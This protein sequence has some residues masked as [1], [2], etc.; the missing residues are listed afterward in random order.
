MYCQIPIFSFSLQKKGFLW[1]FFIFSGC[2]VMPPRTTEAGRGF[3]TFRARNSIICR[4]GPGLVPSPRRKKDHI[5][6]GPL[7]SQP[8]FF[9]KMVIN[10]SVAHWNLP[11][12]S[13][14]SFGL[15]FF[16]LQIFLI[17]FMNSEEAGL[18]LCAISSSF[19]FSIIPEIVKSFRVKSLS[20]YSMIT[21]VRKNNTVQTA[22]KITI[23]KIMFKLLS[24]HCL[25]HNMVFLLR[26]LGSL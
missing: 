23:N 26:R 12:R 19:K 24:Y 20:L 15:Y 3:P 8:I 25:S 11:A 4:Y 2:A 1:P 7:M 6:Y 17:S 18:R 14:F 13:F 5:P 9:I 16:F 22:N 10:S 21:C